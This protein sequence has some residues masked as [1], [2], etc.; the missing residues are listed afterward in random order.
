[1][2]TSAVVG[3]LALIAL[4]LTVWLS[5]H[6]SRERLVKVLHGRALDV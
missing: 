3:A 1:L 6:L 4:Q 2:G 5:L